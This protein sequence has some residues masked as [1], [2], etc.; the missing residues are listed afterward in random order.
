MTAI[1]AND[2]KIL[3]SDSGRCMHCKSGVTRVLVDQGGGSR[4]WLSMDFDG[5][6]NCYVDHQCPGEPTQRAA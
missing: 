2:K 3:A 6:S 1:K 4:A 5:A